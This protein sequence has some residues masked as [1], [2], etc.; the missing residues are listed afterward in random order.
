MNTSKTE[1]S[2]TRDDP[3]EVS[4]VAVL[5]LVLWVGC[6]V[7]GLV[8]LLAQSRPPAPPTTEPQPASVEPVTIETYLAVPAE[9]APSLSDQ[10]PAPD[11]PEA[12]P[13]PA[14][15]APSPAIAFALPVEGPYRT[16]NALDAVPLAAPV[17]RQLTYGV[18]EGR[19]PQPDYPMEAQL[20]GQTGT[21]VVRF[22]V[23]ASGRV[24]AA[25]AVSPSPW[26][27]L[28]QAAV[29]SIRDTWRFGSGPIRVWEV[30]IQYQS[31]PQ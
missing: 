20:A 2:E 25:Q 16:V 7:V 6:L 19:Q 11:S 15:A 29:R 5:T 28:N 18:G 3:P 24:S 17:V 27:L 31:K 21:V 4:L 30:P 1:N 8:G 13:L 9:P 22:T 14:V 23:D 26:P 10:P 12:P